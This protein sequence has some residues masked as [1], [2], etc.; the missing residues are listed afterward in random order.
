MAF[1]IS[2]Y[3]GKESCSAADVDISALLETYASKANDETDGDLGIVFPSLDSVVPTKRVR[4]GTE[5]RADPVAAVESEHA[6]SEINGFGASDVPQRNLHLG[7]KN[8]DSEQSFETLPASAISRTPQRHSDS[9][10][11]YRAM[12][13]FCQAMDNTCQ[14]MDRTLDTSLPNAMCEDPTRWFMD[15]V[16]WR[17]SLE[18]FPDYALEP[19]WPLAS[20]EDE[21][22]RDAADYPV[23]DPRTL[24]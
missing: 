18:N 14:P 2:K 5:D 12:L 16:D 11:A 24:R 15:H 10:V 9:E 3:E 19:L 7:S 21:C 20:A 8:V 23:M 6:R 1:V 22:F 13:E 17:T 4:V